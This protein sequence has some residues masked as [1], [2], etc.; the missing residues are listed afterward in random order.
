MITT[1]HNTAAKN[2]LVEMIRDTFAG[3]NRATLEGYWRVGDNLLAAAALEGV[4]VSRLCENIARLLDFAVSN[5]TL[6]NA[7]QLARI[8]NQKLTREQLV[9]MGASLEQ[10]FNLAH[11]QYDSRRGK[12]LSEI[13]AGERQWC[14]VKTPARINN[15]ERQRKASKRE[16]ECRP[17]V[18]TAPNDDEVIIKI[19]DKGNI[20]EEGIEDGLAS[21][22]TRTSV[23][24]VS[25]IMKKLL[26]SGRVNH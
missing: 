19:K 21:L 20:D 26:A 6:R 2:K 14:S 17:C 23:E 18:E 4:A 25:R 13:R 11:S 16:L 3:M 9:K 22:I 15:A 7:A 1:T 5:G 10:A 8:Y 12:I 24:V